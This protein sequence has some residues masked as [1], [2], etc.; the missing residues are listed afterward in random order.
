M[1]EYARREQ[2]LY[3]LWKDQDLSFQELLIDVRVSECSDPRDKV[4]EILGIPRKRNLP[5]T[6]FIKSE[7]SRTLEEVDSDAFDYLL[8]TEQSDAIL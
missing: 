3:G 6:Y 7:C 2:L 1:S 8:M 4:S 5:I